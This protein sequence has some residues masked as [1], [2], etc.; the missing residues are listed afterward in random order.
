NWGAAVVAELE[1]EPRALQARASADQAV[2]LCLDGHHVVV[3]GLRRKPWELFADRVRLLAD[4]GQRRAQ[5]RFELRLLVACEVVPPEP[6][7]DKHFG[8]VIVLV[9]RYLPQREGDLPREDA[10]ERMFL[11]DQLGAS[12]D[13]LP[14]DERAVGPDATA[15]PV[16]R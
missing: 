1:F 12:L 9:V 14:L 11:A 10:P 13:D 16:S 4:R 8:G 6:H 5:A 3:A 2:K 15:E 7:A